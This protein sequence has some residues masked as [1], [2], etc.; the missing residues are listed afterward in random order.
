VRTKKKGEMV[1]SILTSHETTAPMLSH[2]AIEAVVAKGL[3]GDRYATGKGFYTGVAEWDANV[4]LIQEEPF[5]TLAAT[6]GVHIDPKELR[7]NIVTS[8]IDLLSLVG[9]DFRI[10]DQA[11]F[12]AR[13]AWP[14]CSHIVK[15]SGRR[16]IFQYLAEHTGIG[17]DVVVGGV[18]RIGDP[19]Q[20]LPK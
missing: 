5:S 11:I 7:R 2:Q 15:L 14:P 1:I 6:H 16:E 12:R 20:V 3:A 4:T 9:N 17:V 10:G 18:I 8:G 19:I 13:K